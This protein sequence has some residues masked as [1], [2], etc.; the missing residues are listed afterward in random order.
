VYAVT[1]RAQK[2]KIPLVFSP[3]L[4]PSLPSIKTMRRNGFLC[5][6][7]VVYVQYPYIR[8][9]AAYTLA[10]KF[11]DKR[12]LLF[13]LLPFFTEMVVIFIPVIFPALF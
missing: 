1:V 4:K 10:T 3:I 2:I 8:N 6:V 13:P 11:N 7:K 9:A 12:N 5:S